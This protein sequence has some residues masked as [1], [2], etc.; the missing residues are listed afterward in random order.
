MSMNLYSCRLKSIGTNLLFGT[1]SGLFVFFKPMCKFKRSCTGHVKNID[2]L[3][4]TDIPGVA[5]Y[6]STLS[7]THICYYKYLIR[8]V[9]K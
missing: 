2:L 5:I 1:L 9:F 7:Q 3:S 4:Y 6:H 8:K